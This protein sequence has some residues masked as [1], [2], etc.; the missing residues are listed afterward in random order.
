MEGTVHFPAVRSI[1]VA[2]FLAA[3][4]VSGSCG[5]DAAPV[6]PSCTYSLSSSSLSFPAS[7]GSGTAAVVTGASCTWAAA[8]DVSWLAITSGNSGTGPS[9]ITFTVAGN[10]TTATRNA[11]LSAAG[12]SLAIRQDGATPCTFTVS[13]P[14]Q[15]FSA[16]GGTGS[17]AIAA[18]AGCAW[19]AS[20]AAEWVT[21]TS[22]KSGTGPGTVTFTAAPNTVTTSRESTIDAAGQKVTVRQAA[23]ATPPPPTACEYS[24]S[25]TE[26]TEHWHGISNWAVTIST[27]GGCGWTVTPAESWITVNKTS[28]A[29]AGTV[30]VNVSEFTADATRRAAVQ[31]RWP[32]PTAGQNVWVT[33]EGCR[34]GVDPGASFP[35]AGG[36]GQATVVT[37]PL[38][39][40][41]NI[42]CPWTAVSNAGWVHVTTA[43][44]RAGDDAFFYRVDAN[45]GAARTATITVAG[46]THTVSQAGS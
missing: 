11:S 9:T 27:A 19:V 12:F 40:S 26:V 41:C 16:A 20:S 25:P 38:S 39:P 42:G 43:M 13:P 3:A 44:P 4:L 7:G 21:I 17:I 2:A 24:V 23:A 46:R 6:P 32:T 30:L 28:G 18:G 34:Y 31:V 37:Q 1:S 5:D 36:S 8:V 33:Q 22:A 29:G 45:T 35:A 10:A 14:D 15:S